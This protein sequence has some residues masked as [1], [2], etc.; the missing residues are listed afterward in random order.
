M[1]V[2]NIFNKDYKKCFT[3]SFNKATKDDVKLTLKIPFFNYKLFEEISG[4]TKK[5]INDKLKVKA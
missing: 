4:I 2:K 3:E 1:K 5:M